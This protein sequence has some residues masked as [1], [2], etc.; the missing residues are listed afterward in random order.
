MAFFIRIQDQNAVAAR[1]VEVLTRYIDE[2][3]FAQY[4]YCRESYE[5]YEPAFARQ[6]L[7]MLNERYHVISI[8]N[9]R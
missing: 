7:E 9:R 6:S 4:L 5:Y 2:L 8:V 1:A 3:G